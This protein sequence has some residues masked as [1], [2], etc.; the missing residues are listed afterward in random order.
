MSPRDGPW[1]T[2]GVHQVDAPPSAFRGSFMLLIKL[3]PQ[4]F[5]QHDEHSFKD[6]PKSH[7]GPPPFLHGWEE[8]S[9]PGC[10]PPND[11]VDSESVMVIKP[12]DSGVVIGYQVNEFTCTWL[13]ECLFA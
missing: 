6:L 1:P 4:L 8:S 7:P 11:T 3:F 13:T 2:P 5:N 12:G 9:L 10:V